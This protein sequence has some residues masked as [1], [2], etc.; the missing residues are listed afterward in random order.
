M[1][2]PADGLWAP[3]SQTVPQGWLEMMEVGDL[4]AIPI[5]QEKGICTGE[6]FPE[7]FNSLSV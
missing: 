2:A 1:L 7:T 5:P 3:G 6:V 4:D